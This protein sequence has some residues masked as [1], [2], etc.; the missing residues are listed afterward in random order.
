[1]VVE[2]TEIDSEQYTPA[3][4]SLAI[5]DQNANRLDIL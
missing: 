3:N 2:P 5:G 1:M 4:H